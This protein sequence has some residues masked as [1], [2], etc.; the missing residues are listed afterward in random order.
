[1]TAA[2]M[3]H[4]VLSFTEAQRRHP[5]EAM[6]ARIR[7]R[8]P[9]EPEIDAVL[10]RK[11]RRRRG[12]PYKAV[13][14]ERLVAG[15]T[16]MIGE[17]LGYEAQVSNARWLSG[18]AS[19]LQ[20][21]FDLAWRGLDGQAPESVET[22]VLRMEPAASVTE[23]S[24]RR[25]F[26]VLNAVQG[27]IP[28]PR[29]YWV[30]PEAR[31]LPYPGMVYA[32]AKG[33][34]KPSVG[35]EKVSGLGQNYGPELRAKLAPHFVFLLA[36][37]HTVDPGECTAMA[38]FMQAQEGSNASVIR[39]VNAYRRIWEEDRI[40]EEPFLEVVYQ[41]LIAHAPP[42]DRP[43][44]VHGDYRSGNFL[45]DEASGEITAWLDWEGAVIGDRHQD[46]TYATL[47]TFQHLSED[48]RSVL[49]SGMMPKDDFYA[50]YEAASGL[51]V[52]PVRIRYFEIFNR[53]LVCVLTLAASA[54]AS[55]QAGTHQD[56]LVNFVSQ[57]GHTAIADL[58]ER[59][60]EVTR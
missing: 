19:K 26:E 36:R 52:D 27:V 12:D 44:I 15:V 31:H 59:F 5:D 6:I 28:A 9:T 2:V 45:F 10:T 35:V 51:P 53:Y 56:V 42:V 54:R 7:D 39:Q 29:P 4:P 47:P 33:A 25:E 23:S 34:A 3:S 1:M 30:D 37:L 32:F 41:W 14:I 40:E 57:M 16:A 11:M 24:R 17:E 13:P 49:A 48:G 46:L 55:L 8:Y 21:V 50:A 20:M 58:R 22:L 18:G 60:L 43:S 38:S